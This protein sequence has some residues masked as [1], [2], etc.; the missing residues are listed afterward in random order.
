[1]GLDERMICTK[2]KHVGGENCI[3]CVEH[4]VFKS[5]AERRKATGLKR[6]Y[7]R[8]EVGLEA[9]VSLND[10]FN[11]WCETLGK[12]GAVDYLIVSMRQA[13]ELLRKTMDGK[14]APGNSR[15]VGPVKFTRTSAPRLED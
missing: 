7:F 10:F 8:I 13:D 9:C 4:A 5:A 1:M 14:T 11:G 6:G 15:K 2:E 12:R 3:T